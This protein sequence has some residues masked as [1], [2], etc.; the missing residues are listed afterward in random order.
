MF[1]KFVFDLSEHDFEALLESI[2]E[3]QEEARVTK[4]F[5]LGVLPLTAKEKEACRISSTKGYIE[6]HKR[7]DDVPPNVIHA[8]VRTYLKNSS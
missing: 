1:R 5:S 4:A 6:I 7:V 2:D 3:R 8:A